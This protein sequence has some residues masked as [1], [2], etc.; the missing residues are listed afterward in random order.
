MVRFLVSVAAVGLLSACAFRP[1]LHKVA[2][3]YNHIVADAANEQVLLNIIRAKNRHPMHFTAISS[4]R[5]ATSASVTGGVMASLPS[6]SGLTTTNPGT[7]APTAVARMLTSDVSTPNFGASFST[8]PTFDVGV[9]NSQKF[10][11]GIMQPIN[12]GLI[13]HFLQQGW[14]N[15]LVSSLVIERIDA[16]AKSDIGNCKAGEVVFTLDNSPDEE[17]NQAFRDYV[18][19]RNMR[20]VATQDSS[21]ALFP[22]AS[23]LQNSNLQALDKLD[24]KAFDVDPAGSDNPQMVRR[25]IPGK[26]RI[27]FEPMKGLE[28]SRAVENNR[29]KLYQNLIKLCDKDSKDSTASLLADSIIEDADQTTKKISDQQ[30]SLGFRTFRYE[31][32]SKNNNKKTIID[33]RIEV[34][35]TIRS[36]HGILYFLGEYLRKEPYY[37]IRGNTL[38]DVKSGSSD[39]SVQANFQGKR[40]FVPYDENE[41]S[42][43][44]QVIDFVEQLI[45]LRQSADDLPTTRAVSV[46]P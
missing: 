29:D 34:L 1:E 38:I 39:G 17:N 35:V 45:N 44:I 4:L 10:Q 19:I 8:N 16:I 30:E 36:T 25:L 33:A 2:V 7:G 46:V 42:R 9:L 12:L 43:S 22:V 3:D 40:Y 23:I 37:A 21:V 15:V 41:V 5:S 28:N 18:E 13:D 24:G 27:R 6:A 26:L 20:I 14:P 31:K 32:T 11:Q